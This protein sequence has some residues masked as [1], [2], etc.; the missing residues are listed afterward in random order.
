MADFA[1]STNLISW[2]LAKRGIFGWPMKDAEGE[3]IETMQ[4]GDA[5]VP[6]FAQ[7]PD[8][9]PDSQVQFVES[10]CKILE[11]DYESEFN[12][13]QDRVNWGAGAVP[14]VWVVKS[15]PHDSTDFPEEA[16]WKVVEIR[17][18]ELPIPFS[19]SEF[20]RLRAIPIEIARQFKAMAAPGRHIQPLP[21]ETARTIQ[22]YGI[23]MPRHPDAL[24]VLSLVR[25]DLGGPL[26]N[27]EEA[28]RR[29]LS[30]DF[31]FLV[32]VDQMGGFYEGIEGGGLEPVGEQISIPPSDL[33]DLFERASARATKADGFHPAKAIAAARELADFVASEALVRNVAEF[34]TFYDGYV[35]L[36]KKVSQAMEIAER[37]LP[38]VPAPEAALEELVLDED[39][40]EQ[41]ELDNLHGV[42]VSSV[43]AQLPDIVLPSS[44]LAEAVTAL[45]AGKHLLLSG[46]PGTGKSTIAA[47]L[48]RA[49]VGEE[50]DVVTAT[51]DWTT[52]ETIG[53]Y[54]PRDGKGSLEFEPGLVLRALQRG[55]CSPCWLGAMTAIAPRTWCSHIARTSATSASFEPSAVRVLARPTR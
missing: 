55:R 31:A 43:D 18:E 38:L 23:E 46:P 37:E 1:I 32:G 42:T 26:W 6:K 30:G 11:L 2:V 40:G 48:C 19:T 45:R 24:R 39:D 20:L 53:G 25:E 50:F 51:A 52:F 54:M 5:L 34:G 13:Y 35:I 22:L 36:P 27:L 8:F 9:G 41:I 10:L 15:A 12:D 4:I 29:P 21:D 17:Q 7:N 44:V 33:P 28:G 16:L 47:A 14:F 49:V 3:V